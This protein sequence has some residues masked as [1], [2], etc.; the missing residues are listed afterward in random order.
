MNA[1]FINSGASLRE[2]YE[3]VRIIIDEKLITTVFQPIVSLKDAKIV[4]Y[5]ALSRITEKE[6][7]MDINLLFSIADRMR[8]SWDLETLCRMRA[9]KNAA[10]KPSGSKLFL[11]VNANIIYDDNFISGFTQRYLREYGLNASE[12]VFEITER[13]APTRAEPFFAAIDHY[14]EQ[15]YAIAID[16]VGSGFSGLNLIMETKPNFIKLDMSLI[17]NIDKDGVK[18]SMCKAL[19]EFC[20]NANIA[21]IAEGIETQE[22]LSVVIKLGA[23]YAQGFFIGIPKASFDAIDKD[24]AGLIT[25]IQS[26]NYIEDGGGSVYPRIGMLSKNGHISS[27]DESALTLYEKIKSNPSIT[28]ICILQDKK[29]IGFITKSDLLSAF[30]GMYGHSINSRKSVK[31]LMRIDFLKVDHNARA[32]EVSRLAMQ[33]PYERLYNPIVAEKNGEYL[34]I[35]TVKDLLDKSTKIQIEIAA[36]ANPLTG[37]SGNLLIEEEI[38][39]RIFATA[40]YCITY[41]DMDNF[42]AYNDAYGFVNGDRMLKLLS[43]ILKSCATRGE[44]IGHIGGD[45]FIVIGDYHD[46]EPFCQKVIEAFSAQVVSL[47]REEDVKN[48]FIASKNRQGV[49]ENFPIT[50]LSIAGV[51]NRRKTYNN[52]EDFSLDAARIKKLCKSKAGDYYHIE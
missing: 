35:V 37:L 19:A 44:F 51:T 27:P 7:E 3:A 52:I 23:D 11:N 13:A 45:D 8:R 6:L 31:E 14:K 34:G 29:P 26:K 50:T 47:Y 2:A 32:D 18:I 38:A 36:R 1:D 43:D 49:T 17:R 4:G 24:K 22:E 12:I 21:L 41:Y 10:L 40:S 25:L 16:D 9:L 30:G 28:E 46:G 20:K 42:K 15:R 39:K 33:R 5:E 48:G